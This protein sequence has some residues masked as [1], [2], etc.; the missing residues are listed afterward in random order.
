VDLAGGYHDAGDYIKFT[1]TTAYAASMI[2]WSLYEYPDAF[3]TTGS[4]TRR[5]GRS[6]GPPIT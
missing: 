4:R 5:W 1:L 6:A 3:A 2:A